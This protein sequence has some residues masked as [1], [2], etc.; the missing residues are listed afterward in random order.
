MLSVL[1]GYDAADRSLDRRAV[2]SFDASRSIAGLK[3]GYLPEAFEDEGADRRRS[4]G[5][6][7]GRAASAS[8]WSPVSLPDLPYGALMNILYAEAAAAFEGLTLRS[9][10]HADLAG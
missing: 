6:R 2:Q 1:N 8:R 4:R 5:A 10:R 9:R 3:L 7:S